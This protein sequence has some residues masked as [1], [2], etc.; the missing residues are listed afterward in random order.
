MSNCVTDNKHLEKKVIAIDFDGTITTD[1]PYPITGQLRPK[2]I[3]VIKKLQ[4][5]HI[6]CLWT[7]RKGEYLQEA[8]RLLAD[9]GIVFEYINASPNDGLD[10][11]PRKI[12]AD[13]YIDDRIPG[14]V[15][16]WE[17]IEKL[18]L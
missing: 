5:K 2:A 13:Y 12:V 11:Q 14:Y 18:L 6:C 1:S 16:D 8:V 3:E 17:Q 9:A 4:K 15:V 7:G 10:Q